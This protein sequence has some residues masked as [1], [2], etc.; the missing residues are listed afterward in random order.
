MIKVLVVEDDADTAD[1][2]VD[3]FCAAGFEVERAAT[4]PD[5]LTKAKT[6]AFD[7]ITLDRLL[8]GLD[9]L[10]LL[11][12]LR[13][14]GVDTPVMV[15][16]ALSSVDERIRGLRAGG[17]DYLVKPF[18]LAELRTRIEV[19]AR[20][21]PDQRATVLRLADLELDLLTRTVRRGTRIVELVP[22]EITLLEYLLR[23]AEQ[24]VTRGMLFEHV[25]HYRFDPGTNLVDVHI[26]RLRRKIDLADEL[27]LI[28]TIRGRGFVLRAQD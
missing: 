8:P 13:G 23:H 25:W 10:S 24:V 3:E 17:D 27:P 2:I 4:G 20:R 19:L 7:V 5:G 15:L 21:T 9:G 22:R 28:H 11:E 1:E 6:Q 16:S 12:N 14:G 18:S 26:G